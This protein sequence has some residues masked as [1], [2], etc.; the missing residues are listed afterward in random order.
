MRTWTAYEAMLAHTSTEWAPWYV[1]PADRKWVSRC[2]VG[3]VSNA[4]HSRRLNLSIIPNPRPNAAPLFAKLADQLEEEPGLSQT[5]R[6]PEHGRR[7][8]P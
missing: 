4:T 8:T 3:S 7:L 6:H 2:V 5:P 1:V